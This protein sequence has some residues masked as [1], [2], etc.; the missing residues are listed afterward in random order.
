MHNFHLSLFCHTDLIDVI[1]NIKDSLAT[2][3]L[4]AVDILAG[5]NIR[6][7][8]SI[9]KQVENVNVSGRKGVCTACS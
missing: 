5:N 2:H 9:V 1:T 7:N 3:I 6:P 4:N 8:P